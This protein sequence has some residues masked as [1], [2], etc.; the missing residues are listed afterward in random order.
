[1]EE[2]AADVAA[3]WLGHPGT[4]NM[5]RILRSKA[6]LQLSALKQAASQ[7]SDPI[8]RAASWEY[9]ATCGALALCSR[10]KR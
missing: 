4:Q 6:E 5:A 8:V 10:V 9:S 1:M 3:D 2:E 7:S